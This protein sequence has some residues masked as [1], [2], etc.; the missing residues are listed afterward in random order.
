[1]FPLF[2]AASTSGDAVLAI[3]HEDVIAEQP[4]TEI[5]VTASDVT[6]ASTLAKSGGAGGQQ[7]TSS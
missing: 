7:V 2:V 4:H 5:E 1:V 3:Q 6:A